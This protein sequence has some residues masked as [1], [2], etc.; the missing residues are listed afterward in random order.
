MHGFLVSALLVSA[1]ALPAASPASPKVLAVFAKH[2]LKIQHSKKAGKT[3]TCIADLGSS[4]KIHAFAAMDSLVLEACEALGWKGTLIMQSEDES[5][6][7]QAEAEILKDGGE[8]GL[9][10]SDD[11]HF[12][13]EPRIEAPASGPER[14]KLT[15]DQVLRQEAG[16]ERVHV[17]LE[18]M[19]E[20][21]G[22][23]YYSIRKFESIV[24]DPNSGEGHTNTFGFYL[25]DARDGTTWTED[26]VNPDLCFQGE[27]RNMRFLHRGQGSWD[28]AW[29]LLG[30]SLLDA[31]DPGLWQYRAFDGSLER[32]SLSTGEV[33]RKVVLGRA[34]VKGRLEKLCEVTVPGGP[35]ELFT[36]VRGPEGD[37][38]Y[39][40]AH[41]AV[42]GQRWRIVDPK[43][44]QSALAFD[45]E[46]GGT[47]DPRPKALNFNGER[48]NLAHLAWEEVSGNQDSK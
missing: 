23:L 43:L 19:T 44:S 38:I 9:A 31:Q 29:R 16:T 20:V 25:V 39:R 33:T 4:P 3:L 22:R 13:A 37:C 41:G 14:L 8:G 12:F 21:N 17:A 34:G 7:V 2:G 15:R 10:Y 45:V 36:L 11:G 6:K 27:G 30:D 24:D 5:V 18:G 46:T 32:L 1:S 42:F 26:R 47:Q 28:K 48:R 35:S 40:S